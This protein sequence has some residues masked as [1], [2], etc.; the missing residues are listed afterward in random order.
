MK[1]ITKAI[2]NEI[3]KSSLYSTESKQEKKVIAKFFFGKY[4]W[5]VIEGEKRGNDYLFFGIVDCAGKREY[6]YF[7][8]SQLESVTWHGWHCVERDMY[9][10]PTVISDID[11]K[12]LC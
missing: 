7:T 2:E 6:G 12:N 5:Y 8:L 9:F 11:D 10:K 3:T 1:L 4:T